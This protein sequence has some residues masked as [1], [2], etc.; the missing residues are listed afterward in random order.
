MLISGRGGQLVLQ[1]LQKVLTAKYSQFMGDVFMRT[2]LETPHY[3]QKS[4]YNDEIRK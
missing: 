2:S 4:P 3:R 1:T